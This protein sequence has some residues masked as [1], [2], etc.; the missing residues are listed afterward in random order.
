M[1]RQSSFKLAEKTRD[2][3]K[4]NS[5]NELTALELANRIVRNPDYKKSCQDKLN[6][7]TNP[8]L[9]ERD[10][11][12]EETKID[13]INQVS[14]EIQGSIEK[15]QKKYQVVKTNK[16][17]K[18]RTFFYSELI[19]EKIED[20]RHL[21]ETEKTLSSAEEEDE[22]DL[23]KKLYQP[24]QNFLYYHSS[25]RVYS[26][27]MPHAGNREQSSGINR[28]LL[29][30]LVGVQDFGEDWDD[31]VKKCVAQGNHSRIK[32]WSLEVKREITKS[33][34]RESFYEAAS[35]S[36]WANFAYL[37]APEIPQQ[38]EVLEKELRLL[39][40][41]HGIGFIVIDKENFLEGSIKISAIE[42]KADWNAINRL[43]KFSK[44][45]RENYVEVIRKFYK[46]QDDKDGK[47]SR[48][49]WEIEI[50]DED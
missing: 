42:K 47:F 38:D 45:F 6:K 9:R 41:M 11:E 32:F 24:L 35:N 44:E 27:F 25:Y 31:S 50:L 16:K 26:R 21:S 5:G 28:H 46:N 23:E 15:I 22:R 12:T 33:N 29:P 19:D 14:R 39:C 3:L 34:I 7:S 2:T 20:K 4:N 40:N 18:P 43:A 36:S 17:V 1:A 8:T 48:K 30:D 49:E 37:A 13:L 10:I